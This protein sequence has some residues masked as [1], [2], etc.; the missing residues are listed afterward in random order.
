MTDLL[1]RIAEHLPPDLLLEMLTTYRLPKAA[2]Q[3]L[4][5]RLLCQEAA[6]QPGKCNARAT[7][8]ERLSRRLHR[9]H[10]SPDDPKYTLF[11]AE[12]C[13]GKIP[14]NRQL[15]DIFAKEWDAIAK[16]IVDIADEVNP[17]HTLEYPM[18]IETTKQDFFSHSLMTAEKVAALKAAFP[19]G[20]EPPRYPIS[21]NVIEMIAKAIC[22]CPGDEMEKRDQVAFM[23]EFG[24]GPTHAWPE[25]TGITRAYAHFARL[26]LQ[27]HPQFNFIRQRI[28]GELLG[29]MMIDAVRQLP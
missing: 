8:I 14:K 10:Y 23:I 26:E 22:Y 27:R 28:T 7:A 3:P 13:L 29:E 19:A 5:Y 15:N 17:N 4:G 2:R 9:R 12:K 21:R 1:T 18:D 11:L 25:G 24:V 20:W 16:T 6:R